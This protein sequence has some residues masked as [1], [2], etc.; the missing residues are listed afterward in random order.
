MASEAAWDPVLQQIIPANSN[1]WFL[2]LAVS[3]GAPLSLFMQIAP[4]PHDWIL[5]RRNNGFTI[6]AYPWQHM[7]RRLK[8]PPTPS[9]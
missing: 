7:A 1:A 5:F 4:R 6:R 3:Q 8:L 9:F 2:E